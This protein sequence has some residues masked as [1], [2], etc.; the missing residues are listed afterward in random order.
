MDQCTL[1]RDML[2]TETFVSVGCIINLQIGEMY[3]NIPI[4]LRVKTQQF[5]Q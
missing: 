2:C 3:D 5:S 4:L 1:Y